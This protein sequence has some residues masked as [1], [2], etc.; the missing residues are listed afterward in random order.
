MGSWCRCTST[1]A[2]PPSTFR[3]VSVCICHGFLKMGWSLTTNRWNSFVTGQSR[4]RW[5]RSLI[6]MMARKD[7][8]CP[9]PIGWFI[10]FCW[11]SFSLFGLLFLIA[12]WNLLT[13]INFFSHSCEGLYDR[14]TSILS[15]VSGLLFT[16]ISFSSCVSSSYVLTFT[17]LWVNFIRVFSDH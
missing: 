16:S 4:L 10:N 5:N 14:A 3:S 9:I 15:F 17:L 1:T 8:S 2:W 6:A 7:P 13:A 11:T 12:R